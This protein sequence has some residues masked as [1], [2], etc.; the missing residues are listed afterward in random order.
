MHWA[1]DSRNLV[2]ASQDGKL[3]VWDSYST[4]KVREEEVRSLE[5]TW[6]YS[7][8]RHS[9][10]KFLG[11]DLCLRPQWDLRGLRVRLRCFLN[12]LDWLWCSGVS[13]ISVQFTIWILARG[14]P[15]CPGSWPATPATSPAAGSSTTVRSSPP[16]GTWPALCGTWRLASRSRSTSATRET[17]CPSASVRTR[18][19]SSRGRVTPQP[20]WVWVI[21]LADDNYCIA[22]KMP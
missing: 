7:G 2:S 15:E 14:T 6:L 13:T 18:E 3:I 8:S 10:K 19:P 4:N 22:I 16:A 12:W 1:S 20:R 21:F 9:I 5:I 17:S 11:D